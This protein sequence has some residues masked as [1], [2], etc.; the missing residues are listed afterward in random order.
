MDTPAA[1][2]MV[3]GA[4]VSMVTVS[5]LDTVVSVGDTYSGRCGWPGLSAAQASRAQPPHL[6]NAAG[7]E[8]ATC[9]VGD[10][11]SIQLSYANLAVDLSHWLIGQSLDCTQAMSMSVTVLRVGRPFL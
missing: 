6:A 10:R 4:S 3:M 7:L 2:A 1:S 8:P 9:G 5:F 11:C